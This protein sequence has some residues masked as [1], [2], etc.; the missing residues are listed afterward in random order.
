MVGAK[1]P[2]SLWA[3]RNNTYVETS[4][5][6]SKGFFEASLALGL[7][8]Q[9]LSVSREPSQVAASLLKINAV[10]TRSRADQYLVRPQ[11]SPYL[12]LGTT[13]DLSD[14]Q[15]CLWYALEIELRTKLYERVAEDLG[16]TWVSMTV[17]DMN[18]LD[19]MTG[20]AV[21]LQLTQRE[22]AEMAFREV[23][24]TR[25][26]TKRPVPPE[27]DDPAGQREDLLSRLMLG[28]L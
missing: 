21:G 2:A 16:L 18:D 27:I 3:A 5:L 9:L 6:V 24:G 17:E 20:V 26:N 11:D 14:Y 13:K 10:P 12:R 1:V 19:A 15:L 4:H 28:N 23:V 22:E 25:L 7:R 8:P